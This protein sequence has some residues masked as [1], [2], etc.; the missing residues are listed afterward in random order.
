[1]RGV[2]DWQWFSADCSW[3]LQP[4]QTAQ[5]GECQRWS[6]GAVDGLPVLSR[7]LAQAD[8]T[9]I[10][11][12][13]Q[14]FELLA[15]GP[16]EDRRGWLC[17]P[18]ATDLGQAVHPVHRRLLS[19]CGGIVERFG[20]PESWWLNQDEVGTEAAAGI[21]LAPVL[22]DYAWLWQDAGLTV[23]IEPDH[24]YPVAVEANGNLTVVHRASGDLLLFAPDHAFRGV[25]PLPGCPPYSL[26]T[27]D[28]APDLAS[29]L[30]GCA[31]AWSD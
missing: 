13:D 10:Q 9:P 22:E 23:P 8:V 18:P 24:Y 6:R 2:E 25:T 19:V 7:L 14:R 27:I 3:F 28:D 4:G 26:M 29:W 12:A 20:E 15:W 30:E 17:V 1:M 21:A 31:E 11:V 16:A 5:A